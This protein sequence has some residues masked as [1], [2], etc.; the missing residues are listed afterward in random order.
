MAHRGRQR[1]TT[2]EAVEAIFADEDSENE[3]Y[4]CGSEVESVLN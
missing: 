4:D 3:N 1:F 2:K